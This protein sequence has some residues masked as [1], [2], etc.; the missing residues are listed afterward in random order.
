MNYLKHHEFDIVCLQE[1]NNEIHNVD[2]IEILSEEIKQ[3]KKR[4]EELE[5]K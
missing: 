5:N 2:D 3:L 4:I 1:I